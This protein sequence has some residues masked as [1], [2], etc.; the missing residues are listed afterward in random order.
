MDGKGYC[1]ADY[2]L[3]V[4][5]LVLARYANENNWRSINGVMVFQ[6]MSHPWGDAQKA[7]EIIERS[8]NHASSSA[9]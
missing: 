1:C 8:V 6:T 9:V 3:E 7:V 4:A 5:R 2:A